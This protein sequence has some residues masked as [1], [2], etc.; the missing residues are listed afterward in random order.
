MRLHSRMGNPRKVKRYLDNIKKMLTVADLVWF[1]SEN[2]GNNEYSRENWVETIFEVAF[3]K[4]FLY[5]EYDELIKAGN[6]HFFKRD[7]KSSF[8]VEFIISGF[9]S[10]FIHE[11]T[12]EQ[13]VEMVVYRL[14]ALDISTDKTEHQKLM[15][16]L[17]TNNL[18]EKNLSLYVNACLGINFHYERMQKILSYLENHTFKDLRYKSEAIINIMSTISRNYNILIQGLSDTMKRIKAIV[19]ES[20]MNGVFT[21]KEWNMVEHYTNVLQTGLIFSN[22]ST[23][24]NLLGTLYNAELADYF[25]D[26]LDT[27]SRLYDTILRINESY[28]LSKFTI[29][30]TELETLINYFHKVEEK[31]S[32]IEF[33]YAEEEIT[34]FLK[35]IIAMLEILDIW[36]GQ[37][38]K[39][40]FERYYD[41]M[42]GEFKQTALENADN[43]I[44]SL[45]ELESYA[46]AYQEDVNTGEAFIQLLCNVEK[47]DKEVPNYFG[48]DKRR[49]IIA[50]SNAYEQLEKNQII[51]QAI[52]DR[53]KYCK[54]RL[55]RLRRNM[56]L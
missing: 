1:Q 2:A 35:K 51:S 29:S 11:G 4:A 32:K 52:G 3:L 31:I 30:D 19:D 47:L 40:E 46:L 56:G 24:C 49:V 14:Y 43:L 16:E 8:I 34:Y 7:R 44:N 37:K 9:C 6:L 55:F 33:R 18:Q 50:L 28:P 27:I 12:K 53:W 13:V 26:N 42:N 54:I 10:W 48:K 15:E 21:Q 45:N 38:E 23:I 17:D 25:T 36:F 5:E 39:P 22:S 20:R 41:G